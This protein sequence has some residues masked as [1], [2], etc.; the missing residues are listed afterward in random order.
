MATILVISFT[1]LKRDPRVHRQIEA[2]RTHHTVIAAG[3]GDPG[4]PNVRFIGC[5]Q[6]RR[7]IQE[8]ALA[9]LM[10]VARCYDRYYWNLLHVADLDNKLKELRCD[11][12]VAND[13]EALPLALKVAHG[14]PVILD[15]H[16]Y[17]PLEFEDRWSWR[18]IFASYTYD[19]C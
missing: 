9:A 18:W 7:S 2:L 6:Q 3:S 1:D 15:A 14:S 13:I 12:T 8:K 4:L 19:M 10:L 11:L 17:S 16:E 5:E